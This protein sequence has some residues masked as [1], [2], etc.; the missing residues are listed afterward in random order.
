VSK[1]DVD[2]SSSEHHMRYQ[3]PA[4]RVYLEEM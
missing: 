2:L 4:A 3:K 1:E